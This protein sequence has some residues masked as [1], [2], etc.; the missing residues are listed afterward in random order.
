MVK[1]SVE[2]GSGG[3]RLAVAAETISRA[4]R[5][6]EDRYPGAEIR[7]IFPLDPDEFFA[8]PATAAGIERTLP[9]K[10]AV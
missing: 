8:R 2:V 7:I 6:V 3:F 4:L 9:E 5:L 1:V 10:I